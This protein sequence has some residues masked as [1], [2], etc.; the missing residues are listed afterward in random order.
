MLFTELVA[1]F[2]FRALIKL[3][4]IFQTT[5]DSKHFLPAGVLIRF[6]QLLTGVPV[7][8]KQQNNINHLFRPW[9][10]AVLPTFSKKPKKKKK[11]K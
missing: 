10:R 2:T 8:V 1:S 4:T 9:T 6:F 5:V 11:K 3:A 7:Y